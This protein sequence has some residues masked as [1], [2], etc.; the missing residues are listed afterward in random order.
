MKATGIVRRIDDLGRVVIPK[1]IRRTLKIREGMPM[2]IFTDVSGE[3]ILKKYSP[4]GEMS[5]LAQAYAEALVALTGQGAAVCDN[6]QVIAVAGPAKR[7][8]LRK[9]LSPQLEELVQGKASFIS[10]GENTLPIAQGAQGEA[11]AAF[12][13]AAAGDP[14]GAVLL[15]K[16]EKSPGKPGSE[17]L[18]SARA[19]SLFLSRQLEV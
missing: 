3:V 16:G 10:T 5:A 13:V 18:E 2:E 15:V 9:P 4:V 8:L 6:E 11:V 17:A 12:P 7:E 14:M 1:E 19:A